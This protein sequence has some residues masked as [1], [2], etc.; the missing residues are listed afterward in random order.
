MKSSFFIVGVS[1]SLVLSG[2][3]DNPPK[4]DLDKTYTESCTIN[5]FNSPNEIVY[6]GPSNF[7][8]GVI[9]QKKHEKGFDALWPS[10]Y[11]LGEN[12][13]TDV[14]NKGPISSCSITKDKKFNLKA[15]LSAVLNPLPVSASFKADFKDAEVKELNADKYAWD[16]VW[17][18]P[19]KVALKKIK[20]NDPVYDDLHKDSVFMITRAL[21]VVG[22]E[23]KIEVKAENL[24]QL[25]AKWN[26]KLAGNLTGD[27]GADITASWENGNT[28]VLKSPD[29]FYLAGEISPIISGQ[30]QVSGD[31]DVLGKPVSLGHGDVYIIRKY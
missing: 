5:E 23:A 8:P 25:Q 17:K 3:C 18:G 28:L 10:N 13:N 14:L 12:P 21:R 2:C 29:E 1:A 11:V 31:T 30:L 6:Y 27:I 15:G 16:E 26:G 19:V 24:A 9:V 4:T 20:R 7:G 22:Y